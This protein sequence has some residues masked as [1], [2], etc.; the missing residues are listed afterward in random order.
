MH[1]NTI[2]ELLLTNLMPTPISSFPPFQSI[3]HISGIL[4]QISFQR[5][6]PFLKKW[7]TVSHHPQGEKTPT[8]EYSCLSKPFTLCPNSA[9]AWSQSSQHVATPP[10]PVPLVTALE[11][12]PA[13]HLPPQLSRMSFLSVS[14][15]WNPLSPF[16][17]TSS[18]FTVRYSLRHCQAE[19]IPLC[20]LMFYSPRQWSTHSQLIPICLQGPTHSRLQIPGSGGTQH[21]EWHWAAKNYFFMNRNDC[22]TPLHTSTVIQNSCGTF[23]SRGSLG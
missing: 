20:V 16:L 11:A 15:L 1:T 22:T 6:S 5:F 23:L 2:C 12:F 7:Q 9:Q 13:P 14:S 19:S 4:K 17:R 18:N 21:N 8:S 10:Y 3:F